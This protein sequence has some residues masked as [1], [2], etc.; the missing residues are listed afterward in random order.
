MRYLSTSP[1]I[2]IAHSLSTSALS[3]HWLM[4]R[5]AQALPK[6]ELALG[7]LFLGGASLHTCCL[8]VTFH[9]RWI[10]NVQELPYT[11]YI[12]VVP[13]GSYPDTLNLGDTDPG[14]TPAIGQSDDG[15]KKSKGFLK[16]Y[17]NLNINLPSN[18]VEKD[19][20][21]GSTADLTYDHPIPDTVNTWIEITV[22]TTYI[23]GITGLYY[24]RSFKTN[25]TTMILGLYT[26]TKEAG[27]VTSTT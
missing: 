8:R 16:G 19:Y 3:F 4:E 11:G 20:F 23:S 25:A 14:D 7:S 17:R 13:T 6:T 27:R 12:P 15:W 10:V 18:Q 24:P 22:L 5:V 9:N 21:Q 1:P 2:L 26:T